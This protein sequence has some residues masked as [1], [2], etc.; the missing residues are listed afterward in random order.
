MLPRCV[1]A[2]G[3]AQEGARVA[4]VE[5]GS[6]VGG[7]VSGGLSN[8]DVD[9][10]QQLIGG[11]AQAFFVRA[12]EHYHQPIAWAFEPHVAEQVLR[13]MIQRAGVSAFFGCRLAN[14]VKS[15]SQ[16]IRLRMENGRE[17]SGSVF[18]DRS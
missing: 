9:R 12:G 5:P 1:L 6:H 4:L 17:F 18:I 3:A 2:F 10:Q 11:L 16:V 7:M 13:G 15:G 8:S 14:A